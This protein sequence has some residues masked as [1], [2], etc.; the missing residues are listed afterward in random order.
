MSQHQHNMFVH[1]QKRMMERYGIH[2]DYPSYMRWVMAAKYDKQN[3]LFNLSG[4]AWIQAVDSN[5]ARYYLVASSSGV[6]TVLS[7]KQFKQH[8]RKQK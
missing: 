1:T 7:K 8:L 6:H 2:L 4:A 3:R 5:G